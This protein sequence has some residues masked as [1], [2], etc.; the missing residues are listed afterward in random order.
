MG[1]A[2]L[3]LEVGVSCGL[4]MCCDGDSNRCDVISLVVL[5]FIFVMISNIEHL[6]MYSLTILMS[7]LEKFKKIEILSSNVSDHSDVKLV[8][9]YKKKIG[10]FTMM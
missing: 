1:D 8:I 2:W 5:I 9:N 7:F 4:G 6:F 3:W 10:K